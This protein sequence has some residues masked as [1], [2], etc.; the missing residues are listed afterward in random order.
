MFLLVILALYA[1]LRFVLAAYQSAIERA[2]ALKRGAGCR[3]ITTLDIG[4]GSGLLSMMAARSSPT[5]TRSPPP[6]MRMAW[7][8]NHTPHASHPT[9]PLSRHCAAVEAKCCRNQPPISQTVRH[10]M[11]QTCSPQRATCSQ[12]LAA[13]INL[14]HLL[15]GRIG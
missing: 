1:M 6:R 9:H 14:W 8:P 5:H 7:F 4:A 11:L 12:Q 3:R 2:V 13:D 10:P 15:Q